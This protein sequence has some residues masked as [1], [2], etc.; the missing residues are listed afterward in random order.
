MNYTIRRIFP[1]MAAALFATQLGMGIISPILPIYA[2]S[3]G[4]TGLWIGLVAAAYSISRALCMPFFGW[5][6]DR[7]G[8][9][10]FLSLGLGVCAALSFAYVAAPDL[11]AL[12]WVRVFHGIFS[13]MVVPIA[14]A[15]IGDLAPL[16]EEGKW[17]GYLNTAFF[18]GFGA[19]PMLGGWVADQWGIP[20]A[21]NTMGVMTAIAFLMVIL[22]VPETHEERVRERKPSGFRRMFESGMMRGLIAYRMIYEAS[23]SSIMTFLPVFCA[24]KLGMSK[25]EVGILIAVNLFAMSGLQ[26]VT[27]R[28]SDRL[29]RRGMII[30]GGIATFLLIVAMTFAGNFWLLFAIMVVRAVSSAFSLPAIAGIS[31]AEGRR[32]GMAS[33]QSIL[34][35]ATSAG[36]AV[37]PIAAGLVAD[38]FRDTNPFDEPVFYFAAAI[39]V[40]GTIAFAWLSR[41]YTPPHKVGGGKPSQVAVA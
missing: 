8:R 41:G 38:A 2:K 26:L 10:L 25:T 13:A 15:Y 3:L 29:D 30:W 21:F 6:S 5:L 14:N 12:T 11:A 1:Y 36:M 18:M 33:V 7:R 34:G 20:F 23:M 19:G 37:G 4:A 32:F 16:G 35:F 31:V 28:L 40:L 24:L 39:G 9:R 17:M 27:G 22:F